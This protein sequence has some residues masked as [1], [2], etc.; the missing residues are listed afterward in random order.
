MDK[1]IILGIMLILLIPLVSA[2]FQYWQL[3]SIVNPFTG[4]GDIVRS[5]NQTGNEFIFDN[6]TVDN[7]ESNTA[8]IDNLNVSDLQSGSVNSSVYEDSSLVLHLE[9]NGNAN[10]SSQYGNDGT[11]NSEV[12]LDED[13]AEFATNDSY[14]YVDDDTTIKNFN[15]FT[16]S[17]WFKANVI[18]TGIVQRL[19]HKDG[20]FGVLESAGSA[21]FFTITG[22]G[23]TQV[24]TS[25]NANQWYYFVGV[26]N[27]P[28]QIL[29]LDGIQVDIDTQTG[30]LGDD[31]EPLFLGSDEREPSLLYNGSI[32]SV[33]I[34]NRALGLNEI[35]RIYNEDNKNYGHFNN[36]EVDNTTTKTLT[37]E[38]DSYF[39]GDTHRKDNVKDYFG[40]ADDVSFT[41]NGTDYLITGEV[42]SPLIYLDSIGFGGKICVGCNNPLVDLHV[43]G[44]GNIRTQATGQSDF[45]RINRGRGIEINSDGDVTLSLDRSATTKHGKLV[46]QTANVNNWYLGQPDLDDYEGDGTDFYIGWNEDEPRFLIQ[47]GTGN[48]GINNDTPQHKLSVQGGIYTNSSGYFMDKVGIG[49]SSPKH[50]LDVGGMEGIGAPGNLGIKSDGGA[51]AIRIE[52][53]SGVEGWHIGVDVDGDLN[54]DDSNTGIRLTFQDETGNVGI[55]TQSPGRDVEIYGT[56]SI[57]RL[58]DSGLTADATLAYIEFGGTDATAWNRTGY[59]GDGSSANK[60]LFVVAEAGNLRLGDS[61]S[62]SVLTLS[63]GNATFK[64]N[65]T[66]KNIFLPQYVFAHNNETMVL[67]GASTWT[68]ITFNQEEVDIKQGITHTHNDNTNTTFNLNADGIYYISYNYD[69]IDTSL[70]SSDIDVAGRV[71]WSNGT[72]IDGS[73]F[74]TDITKRLIET[75]LSHEMLAKLNA[76]DE[77]LFQFIAQDSD[78]EISTHGTFGDHPESVSIIIEKRYNLPK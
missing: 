56:S 71:I 76:G 17:L 69:V 77:I 66:A 50:L 36:I 32:D 63:G 40:S 70:S 33:K 72:E 2:D 74:E 1:T 19:V 45:T 26:Y 25:V 42:G 43:R 41:F 64:G 27:S 5:T 11:F 61:S 49:T 75:E 34:Y 53:N 68:N 7:I 47:N 12:V 59:I 29:Y 60:D 51:Q 24:I 37:V 31:N 15:D 21:N 13:I 54:F 48:V 38:E 18:N 78:V 16:V 65:V 6:L 58:R 67:L 8:N 20:G 9:F 23:T 4:Q 14:I 28:N 46:F 22:S 35:Q 57:L 73:V 10:D 62:H 3:T 55:G 52:E 39:N 44:G 30:T